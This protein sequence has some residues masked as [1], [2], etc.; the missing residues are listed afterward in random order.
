MLQDSVPDGSIQ[1]SILVVCVCACVRAFVSRASFIRI[2][3]V[4]IIPGNGI[5]DPVPGGTT[6]PPLPPGSA[7]HS[8]PLCTMYHLLYDWKGKLQVGWPSGNS[9]DAGR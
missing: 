3:R 7:C 9:L 2:F 6:Q 8:V 1:R 4:E 5:Q